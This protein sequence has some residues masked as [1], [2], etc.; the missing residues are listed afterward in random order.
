MENPLEKNLTTEEK[1]EAHLLEEAKKH[2]AN[3]SER[4][5]LIYLEVTKKFLGMI[6]QEGNRKYSFEDYKR[7][8]LR[9][10]EFD[11]R[12]LDELKAKAF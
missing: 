2:F 8:M 6:Y 11:G 3:A 10:F 5:L 9:H 1:M 12:L 7:E 4:D